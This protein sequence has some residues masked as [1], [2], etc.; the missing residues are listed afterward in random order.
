MQSVVKKREGPRLV[1]LF[2]N[3]DRGSASSER[4]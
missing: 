2:V 1:S 3:V 4:V